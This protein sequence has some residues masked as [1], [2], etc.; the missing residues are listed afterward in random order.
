MNYKTH[1]LVSPKLHLKKLTLS[2]MVTPAFHI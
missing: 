2:V 1:E